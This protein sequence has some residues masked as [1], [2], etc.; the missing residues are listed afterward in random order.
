MNLLKESIEVNY[1]KFY[2]A[3]A[4]D[5]IRVL[6]QNE[7]YKDTFFKDSYSR[8]VSLQAWRVNVIEVIYQCNAR[9][10]FKE[11]H[12]DALMSHALARQGAWRV[13]LASL[14]SCIENILFCLYYLDHN[15]EMQQWENGKHKLGFTEVVSYL[16]NHPNFEGFSESETGLD[17]IRKEYALLSKAVHG[18]SKV[19]RMTKSGDIEGLNIFSIAD[20]GSWATRENLAITNLN[21][22]LIVFFRNHLQGAANVNLRKSISIAVP[23][24]CFKSIKANFGVNLRKL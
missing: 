22:V 10:F 12:N 9:D 7:Q 6:E 23:E 20:L 19:F 4:D 16:S 13:S 11:A 2:K 21:K 8:L 3:S 14:R 15:V 5:L 24:K 18:S 17:Q 1:E